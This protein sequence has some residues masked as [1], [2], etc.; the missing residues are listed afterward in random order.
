M[1][2][3][4]FL[5]GCALLGGAPMLKQTN[6][7]YGYTSLLQLGVRLQKGL[8]YQNKQISITAIPAFFTWVC[9]SSRGSYVKTD[10]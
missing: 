1:A 8:L 10:K 7:Y 3:P 2:I 6:S 4:A 5:L 9:A